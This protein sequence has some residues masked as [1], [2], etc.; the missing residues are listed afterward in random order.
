MIFRSTREPVKQIGI[1]LG[2]V[3]LLPLSTWYGTS[4][5]SPPPD[6]EEHYEATSRIQRR[7]EDAEDKADKENLRQQIDQ[8]QA[9][10]KEAERIFY[11]DMFWVAYPVGLAALIFGIL[12]QVQPVGG[13]LVFGGLITLGTGCYSYWDQMAAWQHFLT[14]LLVLLVLAI[15]GSWRFW[16]VSDPPP[17][18]G[19]PET[20]LPQA[21]EEPRT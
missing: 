7:V 17:C 11:R 5:F 13:G 14:L 9:A 18:P 16:P 19:T 8:L 20:P 15:L 21:G 12:F 3:S 10:H 2:I 6:S 1:W 4:T